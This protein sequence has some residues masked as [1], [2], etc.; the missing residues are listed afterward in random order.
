[1]Y[2]MNP[3]RLLLLSVS[4]FADASLA[5]EAQ[6]PETIYTNQKLASPIAGWDE[7]SRDPWGVAGSPAAGMLRSRSGFSHIEIYDGA[8]KDL[9]DLI[10]DN[11]LDTWTLGDPKERQRPQFMSCVY[12]GTYI[13]L[14]RQLPD[15]VARCRSSKSG[16]LHCD[17]APAK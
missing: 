5:F 3:L 17:Q 11:E 2:E 10:P 14:I 16:K 15:N 1:M 12:D 4:L 9:A 6:C 7:F 13:R 8:P